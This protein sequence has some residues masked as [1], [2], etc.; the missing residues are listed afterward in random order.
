MFITLCQGFWK[1]W[2]WSALTKFT[3]LKI[4]PNSIR[5]FPYLDRIPSLSIWGKMQ[6]RFCPYTGKY[7][8]EKACISAYFTQWNTLHKPPCKIDF[9]WRTFWVGLVGL[10]SK[11][12]SFMS[13]IIYTKCKINLRIPEPVLESKGIC[14]IFQKKGKKVENLCKN[15]QNLKIFWKRAASCVRLSHAWS[16]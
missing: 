11:K 8:L 7:R 2:S 12:T 4:G 6:T 16:S 5:I 3:H 14:E 1:I 13:Y 9:P 10:V 15:V